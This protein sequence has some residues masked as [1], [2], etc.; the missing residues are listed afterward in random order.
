MTLC[1][2]RNNT[3]Y[4]DT[5]VCRGDDITTSQNKTVI[6]YQTTNGT[7]TL[8]SSD[9]EYAIIAH[10][11][12][13]ED[14]PRFLSWFLNYKYHESIDPLSTQI[15]LGEDSNQYLVV[16]KDKYIKE[17]R[18]YK[19]GC[20]TQH[21]LGTTLCIGSG[22]VQADALLA[23]NPNM[24]IKKLFKTVSKVN[25]TVSAKYNETSFTGN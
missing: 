11:G 25:R 24:N 3:I 18:D 2:H 16:F 14:L 17:Y 9:T 5:L 7:L 15:P 19:A 12:S 4:S 22:Y 6:I 10:A 23:Y 8:N 1:I 13:M 20:F 21:P